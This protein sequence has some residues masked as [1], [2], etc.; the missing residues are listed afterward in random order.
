MLADR[1]SL[2][3]SLFLFRFCSFF[4]SFFHP[5][6]STG[7]SQSK[8][9]NSRLLLLL[10]LVHSPR[11]VISHYL[12][13]PLPPP[14]HPPSPFEENCSSRA[15]GSR[16]KK[17]YM[18]LRSCHRC[19]SPMRSPGSTSLDMDFHVGAAFDGANRIPPVFSR[20]DSVFYWIL[21]DF[22]GFY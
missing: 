21:L 17:K 10:L 15:D 13:L 4:L 14:T 19:R 5:S 6:P 11:L 2:S 22:S 8:S 1:L 18:H 7:G 12:P 16:A 9:N 3:L 20:Y